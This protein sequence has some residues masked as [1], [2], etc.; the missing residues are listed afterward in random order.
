MD[1]FVSVSSGSELQVVTGF[2]P[3]SELRGYSTQ[4][5]GN[6]NDNDFNDDNDDD[7]LHIRSGRSRRAVPASP[8]S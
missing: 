1:L 8:W 7:I 3:L 5:R 6:D 2:A 4:V